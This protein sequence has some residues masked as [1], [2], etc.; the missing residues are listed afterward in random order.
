MEAKNAERYTTLHTFY[1]MKDAPTVETGVSYRHSSLRPPCRREDE[2][3]WTRSDSAAVR[4]HEEDR[5]KSEN[6]SA[7]YMVTSLIWLHE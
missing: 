7:K 6:V 2:N 3:A 4:K 1:Q 5:M